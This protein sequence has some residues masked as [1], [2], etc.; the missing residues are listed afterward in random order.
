[1]CSEDKWIWSSVLGNIQRDCKETPLINNKGQH[2][3][4]FCITQLNNDVHLN[5]DFRE[6]D[7]DK[8]SQN[9]AEMENIASSIEK[10][11]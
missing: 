6:Q 5:T 10:T 2:H 7:N 11:T 1:M 9:E 4:Q 3:T 8:E